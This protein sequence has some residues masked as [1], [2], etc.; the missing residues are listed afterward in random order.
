MSEK[1]MSAN[2]LIAVI[3]VFTLAGIY[4]YKRSVKEMGM[5]GKHCA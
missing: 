5:L 3:I 1:N 2:E 4:E